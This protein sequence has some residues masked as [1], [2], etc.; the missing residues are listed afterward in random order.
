[1]ASNSAIR[2]GGEPI[3]LRGV[4]VEPAFATSH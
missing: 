3:R 1:M 4:A 2:M